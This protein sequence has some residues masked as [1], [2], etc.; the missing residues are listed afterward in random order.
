MADM[1]DRMRAMTIRN[2]KPRSSGG[3]GLEGVLNKTTENVYNPD[4]DMNETVVVEYNIS[5]IR[6]NYSTFSIDGTLIR[7]TDSKFYLCPVLI[8]GTDCPTPDTIDKIIFDGK[9]YTVVN[10]KE[11]RHA[12]LDCGWLLQIRGV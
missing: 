9:T 1:Y 10:V 4:T 3:R 5:G 11:W 8:D 12:G 7:A 2:L 6:A